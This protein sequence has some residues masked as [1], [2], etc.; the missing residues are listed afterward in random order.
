MSTTTNNRFIPHNTYFPTNVPPKQCSLPSFPSLFCS[1]SLVHTLL[2]LCRMCT[3]FHSVPLTST[4]LHSL[5]ISS[6]LFH[7]LPSSFTFFLYFHLFPFFPHSLPLW[8]IGPMLKFQP[9]WKSGKFQV[10]RLV[11]GQNVINF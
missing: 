1:F 7:S 5:A 6:T 10:S 4:L 3:L 8:H 2:L 11:I 9:S